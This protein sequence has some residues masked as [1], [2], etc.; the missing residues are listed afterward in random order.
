MFLKTL[1]QD[2]EFSVKR[3][4]ISK[5]LGYAVYIHDDIYLFVVILESVTTLFTTDVKS[6]S[7]RSFVFNLMTLERSSKLSL[8]V[9]QNSSKVIV[10]LYSNWLVLFVI[11]FLLIAFKKSS[12]LKLLL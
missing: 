10:S 1:S 6:S 5:T 11:D 12:V 4:L 8:F 2:K 3:L 7:G 9:R